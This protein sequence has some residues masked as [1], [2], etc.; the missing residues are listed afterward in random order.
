M[1]E[2][3]ALIVLLLST[4]SPGFSQADEPSWSALKQALNNSIP[5][6]MKISA[7]S[8][9]AIKNYG[10]E[11][12]PLYGARY[13]AVVTAT[14]N[15]YVFD[16]SVKE[17]NYPNV[18]FIRLVTKRGKKIDV[19]GI[20]RSTSYQGRWRHEVTLEGNPLDG[21]GQDLE[22]N[23]KENYIVRG[24]DKERE[25]I[26]EE[27][28]QTIQIQ[29]FLKELHYYSGIIDG[30]NG[31]E[32]KRAIMEFEID[33]GL[34]G[35]EEQ[36][37]TRILTNLALVINNQEKRRTVLEAKARR[38]SDTE[39]D[40]LIQRDMSL[41]KVIDQYGRYIKEKIQRTWVRPGGISY[42]VCLVKATL[43]T[44]GEV[45]DVEVIRSSGNAAFDDSVET[46]VYKASPLPVPRD[47]VA[48]EKFRSITLEFNPDS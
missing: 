26:E 43:A 41:Q 3:G 34:K 28:K 37:N 30:V 19:Y 11:V 44:S 25:F 15:L 45:V 9:L 23:N 4:I 29:K 8:V 40:M 2:Y 17:R 48:R 22:P 13:H 14:K 16:N 38:I 20:I 1:K 6:G 18:K 27:K 10:D 21:L 31:E 32:T 5:S 36:N 46:A 39:R 47:P 35:E 12:I 24:S 42:L 33:I 7:F